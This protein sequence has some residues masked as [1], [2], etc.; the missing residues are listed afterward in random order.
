VLIKLREQ[1]GS[2][3]E[4]ANCIPIL[5]HDDLTSELPRSCSI[6]VLEQVLR[7]S[8]SRLLRLICRL[9]RMERPS[10][11]RHVAWEECREEGSLFDEAGYGRRSRKR[12][13]WMV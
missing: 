11:K 6:H 13:R 7:I 4:E 3:R 12:S 1:D 10:A 2:H 5:S 8:F 9:S